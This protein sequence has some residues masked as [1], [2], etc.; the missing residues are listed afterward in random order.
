MQKI[1]LT[2]PE[3]PEVETIRQDLRKKIL[4]KKIVQLKILKDKTVDYESTNFIQAIKGNEIKE[5]DRRGKL[6]IFRLKKNYQAKNQKEPFTSILAHLKMT[7]QLIYEKKVDHHVEVVAGGHKITEK[8]FDLPNKHTQIIFA[9]ADKGILFFNDLRRFGY[10]KLATDSDVEKALSRF[11][12]EPLT[13]NFTYDNFVKALG[14]RNV[15]IKVALM[16]QSRIAGIGNIYADEACWFAG[17]LPTRRVNKVKPEEMKKLFDCIP[18]ILSRSIR[19]RGTTFKDY[20]D[21]EGK[22]GNYTDFLKVYDHDG[23]KC[24]RCHTVIKKIKSN[25]RGTHF[26]PGCQH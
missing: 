16:D 22:K 4:N 9:F 19:Y 11:G 23:D 15:T 5:I 6:M 18:K 2:M 24:S 25:G 17:I 14:K 21:T 12:I 10:M 26:C 20:M 8:D 1:N 13:K 3:L 7:G